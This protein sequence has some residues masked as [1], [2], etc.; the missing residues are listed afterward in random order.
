MAMG[1]MVRDTEVMTAAMEKDMVVVAT[2]KDMAATDT[3]MVVM[4]RDMAAMGKDMA[5]VAMGKVMG[6]TDTGMVVMAVSI[7]RPVGPVV[8]KLME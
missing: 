6:A 3:A 7:R 1:A 4:E 5:M 2:G 8:L